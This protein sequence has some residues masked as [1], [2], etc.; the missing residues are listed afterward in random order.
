LKS[1]Q[2]L[3]FYLLGDDQPKQLHGLEL[4]GGLED[5]AF[6]NLQAKGIIDKRFD[7]L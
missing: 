5:D 4:V 2:V 3:D 1:A 7:L 6:L